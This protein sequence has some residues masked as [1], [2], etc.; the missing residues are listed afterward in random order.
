MATENTP[1]TAQEMADHLR[2][3]RDKGAKWGQALAGAST[4]ATPEQLAATTPRP[5][6]DIDE[7]R[8]GHTAAAKESSH[9]E[10]MYLADAALKIFTMIAARS[11]TGGAIG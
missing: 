6:A 10:A 1:P 5:A 3:I 11:A 7:F 2:M 9:A 8:E 4:G